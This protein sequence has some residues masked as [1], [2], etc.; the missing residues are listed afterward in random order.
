MRAHVED[1]PGA[2]RFG[3][4][5]VLLDQ[6]IA[7]RQRGRLVVETRDFFF[8]RKPVGR[9]ARVAEQIADGAVVLEPGQAPD[10]RID[11]AQALRDVVVDGALTTA[12]DRSIAAHDEGGS[13]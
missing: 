7:T 2:H 12:A 4:L 3:D 1:G 6:E 5:H 11:H 8:R 10:R 13:E 9:I